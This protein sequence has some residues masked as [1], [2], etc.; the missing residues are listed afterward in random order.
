MNKEM[1]EIIFA[2]FGGQGVLTMGLVVAHIGMNNDNEVSW[3]PSYGSEMRGGTANC[4]VKIS[5]DKIASPYIKKSDIL[6]ALNEP[7]LKKFKES[8]KA[9]GIIIVNKSM[10]KE[11]SFRKD[12]KVYEIEAND[13]ALKNKNNK[14]VNIAMLGALCKTS[15][16]FDK[17][18]FL[19]GI[20][21]YFAKKRT[22][23]EKNIAVFEDGYNTAVEVRSN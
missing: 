5:D 15:V 6:V 3:I 10:V 9:N 13:I 11:F 22:F 14:G 20:S 2:G 21:E 7:S 19:K 18:T 23:K 16:L 8:V 4:S 12:L 1:K 17:E